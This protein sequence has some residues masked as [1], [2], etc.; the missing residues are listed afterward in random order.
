MADADRKAEGHNPLCGDQ[1]TVWVRM[2]GDV[3]GTS[4]FQGAGCAI[5]RASASLMTA[6]VKGKS[7]A[8]AAELFAAVPSAGHR[9]AAEPA[10]R[11][12]WASSPCSPVCR[13][14][15]SG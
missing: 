4:S 12:P 2:D 14:F 5:S 11:K 10:S 1:V 3:I 7:P 8:E 15:R 13:S 6:A 9:H